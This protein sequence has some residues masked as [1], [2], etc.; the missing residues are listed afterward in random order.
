MTAATA[1]LGLLPLAATINAAGSELES[2]M[3]FIVCGGLLSSTLLNLVAVPSF[4][5]W[6]ERRRLRREPE[7]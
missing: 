1:F 2:P 4:Y 5:V 7:I 6:W 3:A